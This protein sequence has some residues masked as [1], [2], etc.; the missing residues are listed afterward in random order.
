MLRAV[1]AIR[2]YNGCLLLLPAS[3]MYIQGSKHKKA[4]TTT[5]HDDEFLIIDPMDDPDVLKFI[6]FYLAW[7]VLQVCMKSKTKQ[8]QKQ[9][10]NHQPTA[11]RFGE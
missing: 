4:E 5:I 9:N 10:T 1:S 7:I 2:T 3:A 11:T 8:K 6:V